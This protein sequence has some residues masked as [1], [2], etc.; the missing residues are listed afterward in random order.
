MEEFVPPVYPKEEEQLTKLIDIFKNSFLTKNLSMYD[1]KLIADAMF[2]KS[3]ERNDLIIKYGDLGHEYFLLDKGHV[4][5][6]VYKEGTDPNG[7]NLHKLIDFSKF[8]GPGVGFGE[9]ALMYNAK[10][11]ASVRAATN[12]E[13]WVLDGTVFKNIIVK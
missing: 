6:I 2:L 10:R 9:I 12:C 13:A 11:T 1:L 4:E 8:M 5:V 7:Q 3:F